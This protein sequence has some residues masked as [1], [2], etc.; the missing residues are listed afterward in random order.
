MQLKVCFKCKQFIFLET[1]YK[2]NQRQTRF[3]GIHTGHPIQTVNQSELSADYS[4]QTEEIDH[5]I[6]RMGKYN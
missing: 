4:N 5:I 1:T 3:E 6:D 2:G